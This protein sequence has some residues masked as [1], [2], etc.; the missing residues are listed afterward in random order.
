LHGRLRGHVPS[1]QPSRTRHLP[2]EMLY[3]VS[4][5]RSWCPLKQLAAKCIHITSFV[6][7]T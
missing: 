1:L 7:Y 2:F 6:F 4:I 3:I 5:S